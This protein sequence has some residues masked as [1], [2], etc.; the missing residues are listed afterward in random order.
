MTRLLPRTPVV[1]DRL[2]DDP[3][4]VR[5]LVEAHEPYYPVQ[6]YFRNDADYA[7]STGQQ[8]MIIAPNFRGDW[9]YD[10]PQIDGVEPLLF[11][12]GF[13]EAARKIYDAAVVRPQ[14]VYCNLT[15]QL[16]F[17]QGPGHTDVPA[18]CGFDRTRYPIQ[19]LGIMGHSGLFERWRVH[20]ACI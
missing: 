5:R 7:S 1:I 8:H 19:L 10:E 2:L 16:P 14:Q 6:R 4:L 12:E 13:R 15:W 11:H 9:A 3:G 20:I 18:F 17:P